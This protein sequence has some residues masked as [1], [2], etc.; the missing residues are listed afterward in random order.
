L[1]PKK[2]PPSRKEKEG[3]RAWWVSRAPLTVLKR[4]EMIQKGLTRDRSERI[5]T[6]FPLGGEKKKKGIGGKGTASVP[7]QQEEPSQK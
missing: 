5:I 4:R 2:G 7:S 6:P 1:D 3:I